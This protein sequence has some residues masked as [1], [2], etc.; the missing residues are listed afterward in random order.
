MEGLA[1]AAQLAPL[2]LSVAPYLV[3]VHQLHKDADL[4]DAAARRF[5]GGR[6]DEEGAG[7]RAW[8]TDSLAEADGIARILRGLPGPGHGRG[9][10]AL[11]CARA[12]QTGAAETALPVRMFK[13]QM[14]IPLPGGR[15][16]RLALPP[17]LEVLDHCEKERYSE[18]VITTPGPFGL[19]G[20][21]VGRLLGLPVTAF[22]CT[23]LPA[24]A[25]R[26]AGGPAVEQLAW[27]YLRW[28]FGQ[29]AKIFVPGIR[30]WELLA[31]HG[32]SPARL[33]L[34]A[35]RPAPVFPRSWDEAPAFD[36][37]AAAAEVAAA[38]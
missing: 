33:E 32:F 20:V 24:A 17:L 21:A 8:L 1:A 4:L 38:V 23:D 7:R 37:A 18:I 15:R 9:L 2:A 10:V 11:A 34:L 19:L 25:R 6:P 13:P 36:R 28:L 29:A 22:W 12:G 30:D 27:V 31:E 3:A 35:R 26:L 14:E 5:A 16:H